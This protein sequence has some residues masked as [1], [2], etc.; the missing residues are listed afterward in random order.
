[1]AKDFL[2]EAISHP[3][4]VLGI[5]SIHSRWKRYHSIFNMQLS[6]WSKSTSLFFYANIFFFKCLV[7]FEKLYFQIMHR[8]KF[9]DKRDH[10]RGLKKTS[11]GPSIEDGIDVCRW[12][13]KQLIQ[14]G[15]GSP[16]VDTCKELLV[17]F[18]F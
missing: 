13:K 1:M 14:E 11:P 8:F 5:F 15:F 3:N 2:R 4:A 16:R 7:Y 9:F 6:W 18:F 17:V 10:V 12:K